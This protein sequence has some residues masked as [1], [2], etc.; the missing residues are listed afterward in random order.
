MEYRLR[1]IDGT[2]RLEY[3]GR[4]G[5]AEWRMGPQRR[6]E[7]VPSQDISGTIEGQSA[8]PEDLE[9]KSAEPASGPGGVETLRLRLS[10][11]VACR[12][13]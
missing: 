10:V 1:Q 12:S 6:G 2:V 9:L 4:Q 8:A 11:T 3:F 13:R 7:P 5:A